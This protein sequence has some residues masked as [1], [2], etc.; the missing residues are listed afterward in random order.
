MYFI[1][2]LNEKSKLWRIYT[3]FDC[4]KFLWKNQIQYFLWNI[5]IY[6]LFYTSRH[7]YLRVFILSNSHAAFRNTIRRIL[8]SNV[9]YIFQLPVF[10]HY[11]L[12]LGSTYISIFYDNL[13][14][15]LFS[16]LFVCPNRIHQILLVIYTILIIFL[17]YYLTTFQNQIEL[18]TWTFL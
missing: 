1:N 2:N 11:I 7:P 4:F 10:L 18:E 5:S 12:M 16:N 8:N 3:V 6:K 14:Y 15:I 17:R 13:L 9:L